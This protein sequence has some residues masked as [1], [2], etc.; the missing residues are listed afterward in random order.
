MLRDTIFTKEFAQILGI[1]PSGVYWNIKHRK[2]FPQPKKVRQG[3]LFLFEKEKVI[4]W[5]TESKRGIKAELDHLSE[6][7]LTDQPLMRTTTEVLQQMN[8]LPTKGNRADLARLVKEGRIPA[9]SIRRVGRGGENL[10][11]AEIIDPAIQGW[12]S[13]KKFYRTKSKSYASLGNP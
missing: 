4:D 1:T 2:G 13:L 9:P 8:R 12:V 6:L 11:L 10:W 5:L 7:L 3:T